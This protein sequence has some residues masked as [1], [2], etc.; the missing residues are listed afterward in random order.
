ML[1]LTL[2][3]GQQLFLT[4]FYLFIFYYR[5]KMTLRAKLSLVQNWPSCKM[6]IYA[7]LNLWAKLSSYN[8]F[9][10]KFSLIFF[11]FKVLKIKFIWNSFYVKKWLLLVY[12][13]VLNST[14][15]NIE[16]FI[17]LLRSSTYGFK[18]ILIILRFSASWCCRS[19]LNCIRNWLL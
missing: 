12:H 9:L 13:F 1:P 8:P 17:I 6:V 2:T 19:K 10:S 11:S 5:A 15:Y 18:I 3:L 16:L 14:I 4:F 7:K